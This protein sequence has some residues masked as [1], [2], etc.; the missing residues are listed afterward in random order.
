M[1]PR[2]LMQKQ[3]GSRIEV[4][5]ASNSQLRLLHWLGYHPERIAGSQQTLIKTLSPGYGFTAPP[6]E[7]AAYARMVSA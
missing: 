1:T 5:G 3:T 6:A 7:Q 2:E 4:S